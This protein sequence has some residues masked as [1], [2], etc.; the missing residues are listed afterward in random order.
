LIRS[1]AGDT[2]LGATIDSLPNQQNVYEDSDSN[3]YTLLDNDLQITLF[4][5][6]QLDTDSK[7]TVKDFTDGMFGINLNPT[8]APAAPQAPTGAPLFELGQVSGNPV[9]GQE[10][11]FSPIDMRSRRL[12]VVRVRTGYMV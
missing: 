5:G 1:A 9:W 12:R 2:P 3:R 8:T 10:Y 6:N 11:A 7:I 4:D